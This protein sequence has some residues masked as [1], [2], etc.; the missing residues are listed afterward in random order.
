M[1][2]ANGRAFDGHAVYEIRVYGRLD[3]SWADWF[4]AFKLA[5]QGEQ[6]VLTGSVQDQAALLGL[7]ARLHSLGLPLLLVERKNAPPAARG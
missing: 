7:L 3:P 4:G 6:S 1:I 5:I 2:M